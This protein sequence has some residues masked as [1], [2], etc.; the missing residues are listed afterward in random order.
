MLGSTRAHSVAFGVANLKILCRPIAV[1]MYVCTYVCIVTSIGL[2]SEPIHR[3][4]ATVALAL[5]AADSMTH[6]TDFVAPALQNHIVA[7]FFEC[8]AHN[9]FDIL[10]CVKLLFH[11]VSRKVLLFRIRCVKLHSNKW[12]KCFSIKNEFLIFVTFSI[13]AKNS[14]LRTKNGA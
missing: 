1:C 11:K 14:T 6:A 4:R 5:D 12:E 8:R 9:I 10:M 2:L 13:N 7:F 3:I